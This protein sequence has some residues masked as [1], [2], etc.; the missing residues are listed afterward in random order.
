MSAYN[1]YFPQTYTPYAYGAPSTLQ[2]MAQTSTNT[3]SIN[4]KH[5]KMYHLSKRCT[6]L[7]VRGIERGNKK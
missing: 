5:I 7:L 2:T 6:T 3:N 1:N 4:K